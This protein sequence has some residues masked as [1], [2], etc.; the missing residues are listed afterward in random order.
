MNGTETGLDIY[1][2]DVHSQRLANESPEVV[3]AWIASTVGPG[4]VFA[5]SLGMED[6]VITHMIAAARLPIEIFTL[7]TGRLFPET[8]DLIARTELRYAIRIR[9]LFPDA[10]AVEAMVTEEGVN[11]FRH[12]VESRRRCCHVRKVEPLRRHLRK[13]RAWVCGLR[14]EQSDNRSGVSALAWDADNGLPKVCPLHAWSWEQVRDYATT[15]DVPVHPLHEQGFAS[16]GCAP[17]TRAIAPGEPFRAGRWW[18]E[19]EEHKE[20]GLHR[21]GGRLVRPSTAPRH[22]AG[23][24]TEESP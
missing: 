6:Q 23:P 9:T 21:A 15:H 5:S 8:Y 11:L 19:G 7:D 3:L 1:T 16:I 24:P 13:A 4:V 2:L 17:C 12:S 22:R 18:W 10:A 14:A 20:C